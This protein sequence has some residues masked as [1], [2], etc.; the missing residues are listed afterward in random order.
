MTAK[1]HLLLD[2]GPKILDQMKAIRHLSCLRR[3]LSGSLSVETASIAADDLDGRTF[4]QPGF[5]TFNAAV[6]NDIDNYA[7]LEIDHDCAVS[8]RAPPTPIIDANDPDVGILV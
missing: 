4:L 7:T 2:R 8:G 5:R 1:T 3:T 6:I